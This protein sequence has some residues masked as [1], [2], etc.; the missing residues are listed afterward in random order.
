M[1][2]GA[3]ARACW[4]E[5]RSKSSAV[6]CC[7][8]V[9]TLW[10]TACMEGSKA[11]LARCASNIPAAVSCACSAAAP[12]R[13]CWGARVAPSRQPWAVADVSTRYG[14][15]HAWRVRR[16]RGHVA[17]PRLRPAAMLRLQVPSHP[18]QVAQQ[19][20]QVPRGWP[21]TAVLRRQLLLRW[22]LLEMPR[23][24]PWPE[25][26]R[27]MGAL[28]AWGRAPGKTWIWSHAP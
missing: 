28:R 25:R 5:G 9:H 10:S 19:S 23:G 16:L 27:L 3:C 6:G 14:A 15:Q 22:G 2:C 7:R 26:H 17:L 11:V 18:R 4:G 21:Q 12:A 1:C 8:R 13:A 20:L 24:L